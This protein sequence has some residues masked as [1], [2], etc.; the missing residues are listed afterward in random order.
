M[1][2]I[3]S[4]SNRSETNQNWLS[5]GRLDR[6]DNH[7]PFEYFVDADKAAQFLSLSRKHILKLAVRGL[8]PAHPTPG[9]GQRNTW[10]FLLSELRGWMLNNGSGSRGANTDSRRTINGGGSRRGGQ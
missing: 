5:Q 1:N 7:E 2:S 10:R 4:Q 6:E 9:F 3:E 8:I